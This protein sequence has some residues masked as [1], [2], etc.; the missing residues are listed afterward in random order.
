[1]LPFQF[2]L[3]R[4]VL[5]PETFFSPFASLAGKSATPKHFRTLKKLC[6][7]ILASGLFC[8]NTNRAADKPN[9]VIILADDMGYGDVSCFNPQSKIKTPNID[10]L[11]SEGIKF[12]DAH[13]PGSVCVPSRYGLMTGRYPFRNRRSP[14]DGVVIEPGRMTIA[15]LLKEKG[16]TTAMIGKWHLGFDGGDN[17]DYAKPLRG[18]PVDRGFD[19]FFGIHA[20]TDIPPYFYIQNNRA[21]APA[22][23]QIDASSTP[24]WSPIQ[25]AFFR[26]GKIALG[27]KLEEVMPTFT[28]KAVE[29]LEN[30]GKRTD[31]K[32]FFLYV[33]FSAPHTPWLPLKEFR[34]RN[35]ADLYGEWVAQ[36]DDSVGKI[37]KALDLSVGKKDTLVFFTS[38]NGPTWYPEDVARLGHSSAANFR[39]M[40]GDAWEG[41]HREP[42]IA[43]WPGQI[44]PNSES[45]EMICFTDFMETFAALTKTKLPE[46]AGEDSFNFLPALRGKSEKKP[47]GK[48]IVI[49]S[50]KGLLALRQGDWKLIN[51]AG[52]GGFTKFGGEKGEV[53]QLYNLAKDPGEKNNL[54]Q[55]EP[56]IVKRLSALLEKYQKDGRSRVSTA[57]K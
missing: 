50:S 26:E 52:S 43:R 46:D 35:E 14:K 20:S 51:G 10:R 49:T 23:N 30:F 40:K 25:G 7:L 42:F 15:S 2:V 5:N 56:E 28:S 45:D 55:K 53:G 24:G 33:A 32:P 21:V 37:L 18:G 44:K 57:A 47:D 54:W 17:F 29:T 13:A 16:Y 1:V 3:I 12:T 41:G 34:G 48:A 4:V 38:D 6:V 22:T 39:G 36:V 27:M 9:I 31:R 19:S 11:A 8:A